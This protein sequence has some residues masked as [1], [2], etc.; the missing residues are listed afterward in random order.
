MGSKSSKSKPEASVDG[1]AALTDSRAVKASSGPQSQDKLDADARST[2][3][4]S[5]SSPGSYALLEDLRLS[6]AG[7]APVPSWSRVSAILHHSLVQAIGKVRDGVNPE[8]LQVLVE[9]YGRIVK[10]PIAFTKPGDVLQCAED[11]RQW[12]GG[13]DK[14]D[15]ETSLVV[16]RME[17]GCGF[18]Q[19][20]W[21]AKAVMSI[22]KHSREKSPPSAGLHGILTD[23]LQWVFLYF[24][25]NNEWS[26]IELQWLDGHQKAIVSQ[27]S[28][29]MNNAVSFGL[30]RMQGWYPLSSA[31]VSSQVHSDSIMPWSERLEQ[32]AKDVYRGLHHSPDPEFEAKLKD[33]IA[34]ARQERD[35]ENQE[36]ER[37]AQENKKKPAEKKD[38][39]TKAVTDLDP[40]E[41][42]AIFGLQDDRESPADIWEIRPGEER[43]LS[44]HAKKMLAD[45]DLLFNGRRWNKADVEAEI[46]SRI[47]TIL[48]SILAEMKRQDLAGAHGQA[49]HR[50]S[51]QSNSYKN[52]H[53]QY[54]TALSMPWKLLDGK[55]YDLS[56]QLDYYLLYGS[57][58]ELE[59]NLV[60]VEAKTLGG[61]G[62]CVYQALS[63]MEPPIHAMIQSLPINRNRHI[64]PHIPNPPPRAPQ[65]PTSPRRLAARPLNIKRG[66]DIAAPL[67]PVH[68]VAQ[69]QALVEGGQNDRR[70]GLLAASAEPRDCVV[71]VL[72]A[73]GQGVE[74]VESREGEEEE[75]EEEEGVAEAYIVVVVA[76]FG[77]S[78]SESASESDAEAEAAVL[79]DK[80]NQT[81]YPSP[82][83]QLPAQPPTPQSP[84]P[85][86]R[87]QPN[88][89]AFSSS[90]GAAVAP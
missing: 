82:T 18:E 3:L 30:L 80:L 41:V 71:S 37:A 50:S 11:Y 44:E 69:P 70:K 89:T 1:E 43:K 38:Y 24:G 87:A 66:P 10:L 4:E 84:A 83:T 27:V 35:A 9:E 55:I 77:R 8:T 59:T 2:D 42:H 64:I 57:H 14:P 6:D 88:T 21:S 85:Q 13:R 25:G 90:A 60:I 47:A 68:R 53:W 26:E 22:I 56:G 79:S 28:S 40:G 34:R 17:K 48:V 78:K 76:L 49:D 23:G 58:E 74:G 12:N 15:S 81:A 32:R 63:Y 67:E 61:S 7:G 20:C 75:L 5:D 72:F 52:L 65:T 33:F 19:E 51:A 46:R 16:F 36:R 45:H 29:I 73:V 31:G 54:E 86:P 62:P 39:P